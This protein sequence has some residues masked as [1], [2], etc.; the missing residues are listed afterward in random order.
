MKRTVQNVPQQLHLQTWLNTYLFRRKDLHP[1]FRNLHKSGAN[2]DYVH[3]LCAV[4]NFGDAFRKQLKF[5]RRRG[6]IQSPMHNFKIPERLR[7]ALR[8][9]DDMNFNMA[10]RSFHELVKDLNRTA[11]EF[12][13]NLIS[14]SEASTPSI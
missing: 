12:F 10:S 5:D 3:F 2:L 7:D 1:I 8:A 4:L 11:D 6:L 14:M 13:D 9:L